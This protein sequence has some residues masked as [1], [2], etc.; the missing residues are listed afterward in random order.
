M[1]V[2][3]ASVKA[4]ER[5]KRLLVTDLDNTLWDWVHAWYA[6]FS[7]LLDR[8]VELSGVPR[9]QLE[10]EIKTIHQRYGTTEYSNLVDEIPSLT[11]I[12]TPKLASATFAE[13]IEQLRKTRRTTTK[14]YP[15]VQETLTDLKSRGVRLV[16]YT[17]SAAFWTEWRIKHTGLDGVIDVLYSSPDHRLPEGMSVEDLRTMPE[18]Y[19]GLQYTQHNFVPRGILKPNASVLR[20]ILDDQ[21]T[22]ASDAI[23]VGDSLMKDVA[24]AQQAGVLDVHAKYGVAHEREEY[25]LL[26]RVTHWTDGD[27]AKERRS[28]THLTASFTL[29]TSFSEVRQFLDL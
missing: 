26:R 29:T 11:Q 13:A 25:D 28:D 5:T 3:R 14:L 27:V 12:A 16:A 19:Y 18:D 6:S 17:E 7:T 9:E 24:M 2:P 8:L 4:M 1:W 20:S 10:A 22:A 21:G 15:G 23:Y